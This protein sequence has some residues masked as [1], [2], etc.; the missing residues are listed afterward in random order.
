MLIGR[1]LSHGKETAVCEKTLVANRLCLLPETKADG[2]LGYS[3]VF[4]FHLVLALIFME[5]LIEIRR[6]TKN[7]MLTAALLGLCGLGLSS[8]ILVIFPRVFYLPGIL[9]ASL[10][11]VALLVAYFKFREPLFSF[12]LSRQF[13]Y[14]QHKHGHWQ[15]AW[16]NIQRIAVPRMNKGVEQNDL[17]MVAIKLK[18]YQPLLS[19][20]SPRLMTNILMEQRPLLLYGLGVEHQQ[21]CATGNCYGSDLLE[22]E[23]FKDSDGTI[24]TGIQGMLANRMQKLRQRLGFDLFIAGSELDRSEHDFVQLLKECQQH[25]IMSKNH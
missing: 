18:S 12:V 20:I 15:I 5:E 8:L 21:Q 14:Y 23:R 4:Y 1:V 22:D 25:V 17:A 24:Y 6:A 13:V 16:D 19:T 2:P 11:I 3:D 10:S 9:L 7:N